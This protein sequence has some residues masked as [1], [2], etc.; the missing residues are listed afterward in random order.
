M[1]EVHW[2]T[3]APVEEADKGSKVMS[4]FDLAIDV[5]GE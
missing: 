3:K 5:I 1:A 4:D 2:S